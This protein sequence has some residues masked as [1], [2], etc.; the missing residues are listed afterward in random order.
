M[1]F[2]LM[3]Y[4]NTD[5]FR[6][7]PDAEKR[8]ISDACDTWFE[9]L[10]RTGQARSMNRLHDT[11]T[12]ATVRK[13]GN[14]FLVTDGPFAETKEVFG[15]YAIVECRDRA[16]ALEVAKTFPGVEIDLTVEVRPIMTDAE[17]KQR[18]RKA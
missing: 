10:Q 5:R 18:W 1:Q 4:Q 8:R 17:E 2:M 9:K 6:Q 12:A 3:V 7:L 11:P 14:G 15:G 16:E 13:S